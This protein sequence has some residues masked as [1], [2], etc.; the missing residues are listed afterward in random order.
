MGNRRSVVDYC[1]LTEN[2]TFTASQQ[3]MASG[4]HTQRGEPV[5]IKRGPTPRLMEQARREAADK[6]YCT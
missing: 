5:W 1:A 4:P 6:T 3:A 2:Y